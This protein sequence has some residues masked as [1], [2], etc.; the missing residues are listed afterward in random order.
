MGDY[1]EMDPHL[2][3]R[4]R[5][6]LLRELSYLEEELDVRRS[7]DRHLMRVSER[8]WSEEGFAVKLS[9]P[10]GRG[11]NLVGPEMGFNAH[12][13]TATLLEVPPGSEEGTYHSHG[14]AIKY[15]LQGE[16]TEIV[17]DKVFSVKAG[18]A[19]FIP[20]NAWHG[21]QNN[22]T[23]PIRILATGQTLVPYLMKM[24]IQETVGEGAARPEHPETKA[25]PGE[26]P[27]SQLGKLDSFQLYRRRRALLLERSKLEEE[28]NRRRAQDRLLMR[29]EDL[30]WTEEGFG[31]KLQGVQ[32]RGASVITP[33]LGFN[34]HNLTATLLEVPPGSEEGTYHYHGEAVKYYV[35]GSATEIVGDKRYEVT[36]GDAVFIPANTW[37]GTQNNSKEPVLIYAV[38]HSLVPNMKQHILK[39]VD[40]P[41]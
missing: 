30:D 26:F 22:G 33:E 11:A 40:D 7:Q 3:R 13:L 20:A 14:E 37:H 23:E 19:A 36:A 27:R 21:T 41:E 29:S 2:I 25:E 9:G 5:Y 16:G 31:L 17:G 4:A 1:L 10:A 39:S 34:I 18:D 32:G 38:A 35:K 28:L 12:N 15:Y 24:V 6:G 8:E